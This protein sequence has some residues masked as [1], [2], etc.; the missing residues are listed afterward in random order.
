MWKTISTALCVL[1]FGGLAANG[2]A[3]E[4]PMTET[5]KIEALIGIVDALKDAL[6]VRNG[7]EYD[8]HAAAAHMRDKW[9]WKRKEIK[10][11]R[12]FIRL[13]ASA[14]SISGE[15]YLIRFKDG[16]EL[17]SG[18]FLLAELEKLEQ[19]NGKGGG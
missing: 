18:D 7:R 5:G 2:R 11:A 8:C 10:T 15:P 3:D 6:F 9:A 14:S 1:L 19:T 17:K 16:R 4:K 12:D 13:A